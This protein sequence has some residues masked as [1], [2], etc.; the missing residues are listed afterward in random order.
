VREA[1]AAH[2]PA[3]LRG[4][5]LKLYYATQASVNPPTF[6]F[7]VNDPKLIHFTYERFLENQLRQA[8]DFEGTP[9]RLLFKP[10]AEEKGR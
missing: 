9:L 8:L 2:P 1:V 3:T 10:H 5:R 6:V 7:F 4:R